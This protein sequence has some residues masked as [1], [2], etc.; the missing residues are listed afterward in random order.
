MTDPVVLAGVPMS[1]AQ[2]LG[3][4]LLLLFVVG[5]GILSLGIALAHWV[6]RSP[7]SRNPWLP[8]MLMWPIALHPLMAASWLLPSD[9]RLNDEAT[10][11]L[12]QFVLCCALMIASL[13]PWVYLP[14]WISL[15][16]Q[17]RHV[18]EQVDALSLSPGDIWTFL[19]YPRLKAAVLPGWRLAML[20]VL[21]DFSTPHLFQVPVVATWTYQ[22]W[23]MD[24]L[25]GQIV[26]AMILAV[27]GLCFISGLSP[28]RIQADWVVATPS[29]PEMGK[30][31]IESLVP[32]LLS[33][34]V[35]W[36]FIA[37]LWNGWND[38]KLTWTMVQAFMDRVSQCAWVTLLAL[39]WLVL[40]LRG[41]R[42]PQR[43]VG[44]WWWWVVT[45]IAFLVWSPMKAMDAWYG[46]NADENW[47]TVM[48]PLVISLVL[49]LQLVAATYDL[50]SVRHR[51]LLPV[52]ARARELTGASSWRFWRYGYIPLL[53]GD[54]LMV[55]LL[56]GTLA[57]R[58]PML[59]GF[60]TA[61]EGRDAM[62]TA[63]SLV[64][65][66]AGL[67]VWMMVMPGFLLIPLWLRLTWRRFEPI[68]LGPA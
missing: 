2:S 6:I 59:L 37:G 55:A 50:L 3:Y 58:D 60:L 56:A 8:M 29:M 27:L 23:V 43:W 66:Q 51:R 11:W 67:S 32:L 61:S 31:L 65:G 4:T 5:V 35:L 40:G 39:L 47:R 16:L 14:A 7:W 64:Q 38:L 62:Q 10:S 46:W 48:P 45:G 28:Q 21:I 26:G 36:V 33:I 1:L 49:T 9:L 24:L 25:P 30:G 19:T 53:G 63:W 15:R 12:F 22:A 18:A 57:W 17:P 42:A 41:S 52:V 44:W 54:Y 68:D 20:L 34:G 13:Y